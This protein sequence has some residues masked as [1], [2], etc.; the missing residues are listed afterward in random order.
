MG[1]TVSGEIISASSVNIHM[2][3]DRIYI[4]VI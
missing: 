4:V 3:P 2:Q 1:V